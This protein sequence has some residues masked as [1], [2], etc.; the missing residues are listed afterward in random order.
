[1]WEWKYWHDPAGV[2]NA[3]VEVFNLAR[4]QHIRQSPAEVENTG[5]KIK[6]FNNLKIH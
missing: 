5:V 3:G 4:Y 2:E 6:N 1:M